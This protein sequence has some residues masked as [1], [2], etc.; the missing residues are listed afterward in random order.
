MIINGKPANQKVREKFVALLEAKGVQFNNQGSVRLDDLPPIMG[1]KNADG[2][3]KSVKRKYKLTGDYIDIDDVFYLVYQG[4]KRPAK[5]FIANL[6]EALN[7]HQSV[8]S[9][10]DQLFQFDGWQFECIY[11][12]D[13]KQGWITWIKG[14]DVVRF[15]ELGKPSD[16]LD[17]IKKKYKISFGD[18]SRYLN[19]QSSLR[20]KKPPKN[21]VFIDLTGLFKL[22]RKS[23]AKMAKRFRHWVD[24]TVLPNL[25]QH[26][27]YSIQPARLEIPVFYDNGDNAASDFHGASVVY[28]GYVGKI[29]RGGRIT[30]LDSGFE[31]TFKFGLSTDVFRRDCVEHRKHF[32]MFEIVHI[33]KTSNA[34]VVETLFKNDLIAFKLHRHREING[35]GQRELFTVT[36]THTIQS[37]IKRLETIVINNP[38]TE[39]AN[40]EKIIKDADIRNEQH[41]KMIAIH[42]IADQVRLQKAQFKNSNV[43]SEYLKYKSSEAY[44]AKL[45]YELKTKALEL[46]TQFHRTQQA[47]IEHGYPLHAIQSPIFNQTSPFP[48]IS[49]PDDNVRSCLTPNLDDDSA[50]KNVQDVAVNPPSRQVVPVQL[51]LRSAQNKRT[52]SKRSRTP[53][54]VTNFSSDEESSDNT[55]DIFE[56][57]EESDAYASSDTPVSPRKEFVASGSKSTMTF[58]RNGI[59]HIH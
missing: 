3:I 34:A 13:E 33:I 51:P 14:A 15:L 8:I 58:V 44:C 30:T 20:F 31:H 2:Y 52:P 35:R 37:L 1:S 47:A 16:V 27:S 10:D 22:I 59:K 56:S 7:D 11:I 6:K 42:D 19:D 46:Q 18:L 17:R 38:S 39:V 25:L 48:L 40:A 5:I 54:S 49:T 55:T 57:S 24:S 4:K 23:N 12:P 21:T 53:F 41:L 9:V 36:N 29:D 32:E 50:S 28:I 26:G 43:Y 45:E